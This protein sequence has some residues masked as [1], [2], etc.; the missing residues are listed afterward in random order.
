[1]CFHMLSFSSCFFTFCW[2]FFLFI[3]LH[4][5]LPVPLRLWPK[6]ARSH[7]HS[8]AFCS[9]AGAATVAEVFPGLILDVTLSN[10]CLACELGPSPDSPG[11]AAWFQKHE[12]QCQKNTHHDS[13]AMATETALVMWGWSLQLHN[14]RYME[15]PGDGD[16]DGKAH[17]KVNGIQP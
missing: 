1:M 5:S 16:G 8:Q 13:A 2:V 17:S 3:F 4:A 9:H 10:Y 15:M 11:Y 6:A 12:R 14:F 7:Q